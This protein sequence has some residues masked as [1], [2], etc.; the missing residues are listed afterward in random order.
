MMYFEITTRCNI[1]CAHCC[2]SYPRRGGDMSRETFLAG[3]RPAEEWGEHVEIGGG[4]P[5]LHP[6]L[7][8]LIGLAMAH[9]EESTVW[10]ATNG[11][12]REPTVRLWRMARDGRIQVELSV[13]DWHEA[14]DWD[15][16]KLFQ[17]KR[18]HGERVSTLYAVRHVDGEHVIPVGRARRNGLGTH[19]L[20]NRSHDCPC[21]TP[22]VR[23]DGALFA[24]GCQTVQFGTVLAPDLD[25]LQ[26]RQDRLEAR[27]G[28]ERGGNHC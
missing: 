14:I 3:V 6:L 4:E 10:L 1:R 16:E 26:H 28:V 5:T 25:G 7:F 27:Y 18:E 2:G 8:D 19:G 22:W 9:A 12:E 20:R 23:H 13:D 24:C 21:S 11:K 17:P 15:V